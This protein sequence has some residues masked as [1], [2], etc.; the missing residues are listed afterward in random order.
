MSAT[1]AAGTSCTD[2]RRTSSSKSTAAGRTSGDGRGRPASEVQC[3]GQVFCRGDDR[4]A[5]IGR[6]DDDGVEFLYRIRA[7]GLHD[8]AADI[9]GR[10]APGNDVGV[11]VHQPRAPPSS[12]MA[13]RHEKCRQIASCRGTGAERDAAGCG[14]SGD[15]VGSSCCG[16]GAWRRRRRRRRS[17][18]HGGH[19]AITA[20][21]SGVREW[22][23]ASGG[24]DSDGMTPASWARP[25]P[26]GSSGAGRG[27]RPCAGHDDNALGLRAH[28]EHKR[29]KE[30]LQ[31]TSQG[32][33]VC[34]LANNT[35]RT[36]L[37]TEVR[38]EESLTTYVVVQSRIPSNRLDRARRSRRLASPR[39]FFVSH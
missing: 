34:W 7:Q 30:D 3:V 18:G 38:R 31:H 36:R 26:C 32:F 35:R 25:A 8:E 28:S 2:P 17:S 13:A 23:G 15:G 11:D 12:D 1:S 6:A 37:S 10:E 19:D 24:G 9:E 29:R 20:A 4:D 33:F 27:P 22:S 21:G 39:T 5:V 16:G 14:S